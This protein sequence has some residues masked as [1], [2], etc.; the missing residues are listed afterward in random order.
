MVRKLFAAFASAAVLGIASPSLAEPGHAGHDHASRAGCP[1]AEYDVTS[2]RPH[3][4]R[5]P[6]GKGGGVLRRVDGASMH[7]QAEPE[8]TAEWLQLQLTQH[9]AATRGQEMP[10]C[11]FDV[12]GAKVRV[13]SA[14]S[15][16][17]VMVTANDRDAAQEILRRAQ[18]VFE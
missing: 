2:V 8:L 10:D 11:P 4:V 3:E 17:V 1:L 9:M 14:G 13:D 15:G 12:E 16:F 7:V 6:V 18:Q 5:K